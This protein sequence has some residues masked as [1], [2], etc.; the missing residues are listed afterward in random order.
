MNLLFG[1]EQR[2]TLSEMAIQ[3]VKTC[4]LARA[5]R[6][7]LSENYLTGSNS[8][9]HQE[10]MDASK[11]G[12]LSIAIDFDKLNRSSGLYN[13]QEI[14]TYQ[15]ID[16]LIVTVAKHLENEGCDYN[17]IGQTLTISWSDPDTVDR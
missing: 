13:P 7:K 11:N 1:Y 9:V 17:V 3:N 16:Q 4:R 12:E 10:I 6:F 15:E 5:N 8:P 2:K 14:Y